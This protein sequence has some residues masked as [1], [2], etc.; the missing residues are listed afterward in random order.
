MANLWGT[1]AGG[2]GA[3]FTWVGL[4]LLAAVLWGLQYALWGQALKAVSPVV[5]MWWYCLISMV[6][7][8]AFVMVKGINLEANMLAV[9]W[10]L[11]GLLVVIAILG[12]AGNVTMLSGFKMANP[13]VVTMITASAPLFSAAFA[14]IFFKNV[15]VNWMTV[16]GFALILGGVGVV[17]YSR[18]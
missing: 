5:G 9:N 14:Y 16:V 18:G 13:T 10:P 17:A 15:D 2:S 12:F 1:L 4:A 7:Y 3:L 11:M 6:L 8:T